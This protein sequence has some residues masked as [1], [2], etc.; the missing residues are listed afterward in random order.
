MGI[1]EWCVSIG[2]E[3]TSRGIFRWEAWE[4]E[5]LKEEGV[6]SLANRG[7]GVFLCISGANIDWVGV[8]EV[9]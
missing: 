7:S 6:G 5:Q 9:L 8:G 1:Q 2:G 4:R 3:S